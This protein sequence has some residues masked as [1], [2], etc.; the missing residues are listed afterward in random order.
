MERREGRE[1]GKVYEEPPPGNWQISNA[2]AH[3]MGFQSI[4]VA[5]SRGCRSRSATV[6]RP[7]PL[8]TP[9]FWL[10]YTF[11][12][13]IS[14]WR[15]GVSDQKMVCIWQEQDRFLCQVLFRFLKYL[16]WAGKE[17]KVK[18]DF[19]PC[20]AQQKA[21]GA[22]RNRSSSHGNLGA[23]PWKSLEIK[24]RP[25][26]IKSTV[27]KG[28]FPPGHFLWFHNYLTNVLFDAY[29]GK[30]LSISY[31]YSYPYSF[32]LESSPCISYIEC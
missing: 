18:K 15:W 4:A 21:H 29:K 19:Q 16:I 24:E 11:Q 13:I 12:I 2:R 26:Y 14:T 6:C 27:G 7:L 10:T 20:F 25:S 23:T 28:Q 17:F 1:R 30:F 32:V 9:S 22:A 5:S 3:S 8:S 31:Q